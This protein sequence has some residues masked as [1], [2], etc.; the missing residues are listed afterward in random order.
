MK[1]DVVSFENPI[2]FTGGVEH[3]AV[4]IVRA[5][6]Q[7]GHQARLVTRAPD[8]Q[9]PPEDPWG[10]ETAWIDVPVPRGPLPAYHHQRLTRPVFH[11]RL[12]DAVEGADVVHSQDEAGLGAHGTAPLVVTVHTDVLGEY[13]AARKP[14]PWGIPQRLAVRW[15]VARW[16]RYA[17]KTDASI[18]VAE[19]TAARMRDELGFDPTVIPNGLTPR[20]PID[21]ETAREA[22]GTPFKTNLLY[23]GRLAEVKRVDRLLD[24]LA[25]LP[26]DVGLTV[27]GDGP[28]REALEA[29]ARERGLEDRVRFLGYVPEADK[30]D[31]LASAD[32][33]AL[34]SMHEGQPI[35]LLE[36]LQQG[37]P[38]VVSRL[39]WLPETLHAHAH[40]APPE[41]GERR[42]AEAVR[43]ALDAGRQEDVDVPSWR[44]VAEATV[45]VYERALEDH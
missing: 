32:A 22:T 14:L 19:A 31:L 21:R 25:H 12:P 42:L 35:V 3:H 45:E 18:A 7:L 10:I 15:D 40:E 20:E 29:S 34:P 24:A 23:F 9:L 1:V 36:A 27:G 8:D 16:R 44:D 41:A 43:E 30:H 37:V 5:L 2:T 39:G 26:E 17:E 6:D 13:E 11:A 4:E 33:L 38:V 28:Q